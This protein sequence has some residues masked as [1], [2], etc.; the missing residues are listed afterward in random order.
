MNAHICN[1][2]GNRLGVKHVIRFICHHWVYLE[3][4]P[5]PL[6]IPPDPVHL[7]PGTPTRII[8]IGAIISQRSIF[9]GPSI[10]KLLIYIPHNF[11]LEVAV[12]DIRLS[13]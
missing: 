7:L 3:Y 4:P 1:P 13:E 9:P 5:P 8:S 11:R 10:L 12:I 2:I 6:I